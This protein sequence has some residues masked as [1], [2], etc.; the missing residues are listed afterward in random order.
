MRSHQVLAKPRKRF[1]PRVLCCG[2]IV[3]VRTRFI[4]ER[5][6]DAGINVNRVWDIVL[7][8][9]GFKRACRVRRNA[10]I[11]FRVQTQ[12]WRAQFRGVVRV[13][14]S[15]VK[16]DH[17]ANRIALRGSG[18]RVR[19]RLHHNLSDS[20]ASVRAK[21]IRSLG[22]LAKYEHLTVP[23]RAQLQVACQRAL[24]TDEKT[25]W[26]RAYIVRKEAEEAQRYV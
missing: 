1:L 8:Q 19:E 26:D 24:G 3:N 22:K 13:K 4:E 14:W 25:E 11:L 6:L 12:H 17:R 18:V 9:L 7:L 2:A 16:R 10:M 5:V 20:S 15:S 23:E 21:A